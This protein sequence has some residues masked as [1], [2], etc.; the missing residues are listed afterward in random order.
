[1]KAIS[2]GL[3]V[4]FGLTNSI[5]SADFLGEADDAYLGVQITMPLDSKSM[6]L[7]SGH[8]QYNYLLIEQ[9]DGIIDGITLNQDNNGNQILNYL[10]PSANF[11]INNSRLSEYAVPIVRLDEQASTKVTSSTNYAGVGL[12]ALLAV[13]IIIEH[14][15]KKGWKAVE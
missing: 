5:A 10:T 15:L 11:D 2:K 14:D 3:L 13:G 12:I 6:G 1:M 4:I 7:F 9:K 8:N